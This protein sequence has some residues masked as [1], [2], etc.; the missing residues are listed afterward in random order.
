[1][2]RFVIPTVMFL[3][4]SLATVPGAAADED[5]GH[6]GTILSGSAVWPSQPGCGSAPDCVAWLQSGCSAALAGRDPALMTSIEDVT[7]LAETSSV[8]LINYTAVIPDTPTWVVPR[9]SGVVVQFWDRGCAEIPDAGIVSSCNQLADETCTSAPFSIPDA[10]RWITIGGTAAGNS[11]TVWALTRLGTQSPPPQPA[12]TAAASPTAQP[13]PTAEPTAEPTPVERSVRLML[14]GHLRAAGSVASDEAFCRSGVAVVLQRKR[15]AGWTEVGSATTGTDGTF[16][17]GLSDR[18][19]R[20][21]TIV[22]EAADSQQRT[23]G[24]AVSG[25]QRHRH[26]ALRGP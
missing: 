17:L 16:S 5:A 3:A 13:S 14:R 12:P 21:R 11:P 20:Y 4:L 9:W 26:G 2:K 25:T 22:A 19:G 6:S 8:A 10:A 1:M 15:S 18:P 7:A 23:C 24:G